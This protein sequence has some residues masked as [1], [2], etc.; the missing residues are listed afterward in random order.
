[1]KTKKHY[2]I[3]AVVIGILCVPALGE[4]NLPLPED[5]R[6][7]LIGQPNPQLF[8][9]KKLH[10]VI[11]PVDTEPNRHGLVWEELEAKAQHKL[12]EAGIAAYV[13]INHKYSIW[14]YYLPDLRVDIDMLKLEDSHQYV[15]HIQTF[16]SDKVRLLRDPSL[17]IE[18]D[19]WKVSPVMQTVSAENMPARVTEVVLNQVEAFIHAYL[20]ANPPGTRPSAPN[21]ITVK[22]EKLTKPDAKRTVAEYKYVASKNSKVF[23]KPDCRWVKRI[24]AKNLVGYNNRGEAIQAGKRPCK[25]CKP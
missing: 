3:L 2:F 14:S 15:F 5:R 22:P 18:A 23:H 10:I 21:D 12:K 4:I 24:L 7:I 9:I 1:M 16:F 6:P 8:G 25:L 13:K 11:V 19:V 20:A 17:F